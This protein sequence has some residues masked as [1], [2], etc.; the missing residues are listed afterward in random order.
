MCFSSERGKVKEDASARIENE[1]QKSYW[2]RIEWKLPI[3]DPHWIKRKR[4]FS[5]V[6]TIVRK[7]NASKSQVNDSSLRLYQ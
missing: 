5:I 1:Y 7:R 6:M 2:L 3:W 4:A